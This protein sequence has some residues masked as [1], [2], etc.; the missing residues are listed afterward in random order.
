M[1]MT[2]VNTIVVA[3]GHGSRSALVR[4]DTTTEMLTMRQDIS[5]GFDLS[6]IPQLG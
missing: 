4:G 5:C 3:G 1:S 6:G 2:K